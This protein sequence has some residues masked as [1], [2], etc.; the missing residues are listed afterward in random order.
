ML[1]MTGLAIQCVCLCVCGGGVRMCMCACGDQRSTSDVIRLTFVS[2]VN[3]K[4]TI[5]IFKIGSL[6]R[7]WGSPVRLDWLPE[8]P[9][10]PPFSTVPRDYACV[11]ILSFS[12]G[13]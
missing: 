6:T 11:T 2:D 3:Q 1:L 12:C 4:P 5:L 8:S 9:R 13:F 7:T 10:D